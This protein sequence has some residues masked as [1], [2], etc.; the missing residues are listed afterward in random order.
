MLFTPLINNLIRKLCDFLPSWQKRQQK[1]GKAER[2]PISLMH[3]PWLVGD[4]ILSKHCK[5]LKIWKILGKQLKIL[6]YCWKGWTTEE[7][8]T[9]F[10]FFCCWRLVKI[11]NELGIQK[12]KY[13][14][15][16]WVFA[17]RMYF[18]CRKI[19]YCQVCLANQFEN[20]VKLRVKLENW[21]N[22]ANF[23]PTQF[24][25]FNFVQFCWWEP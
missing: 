16:Y 15:N 23:W 4:K 10:I 6:K 25:F 17:G 1:T 21:R 3:E 20:S 13:F 22:F 19:S 2:F 5:I 7:C 24:Q 9:D 18:G 8:S 14:R 12:S 11:V